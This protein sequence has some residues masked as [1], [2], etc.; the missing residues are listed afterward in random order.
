MSHNTPYYMA[1]LPDQTVALRKA[2]ESVLEDPEIM[3]LWLA[4]CDTSRLIDDQDEYLLSLYGEYDNTL[5]ELVTRIPQDS[6]L[7]FALGGYP[8]R[9]F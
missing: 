7:R 8:S 5:N 6:P 4:L 9:L 3:A 1:G 2:F